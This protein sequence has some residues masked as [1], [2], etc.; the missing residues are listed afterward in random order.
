MIDSSSVRG[1]YNRFIQY[2][3]T[4]IIREAREILN[5]YPNTFHEFI[6]TEGVWG[7]VDNDGLMYFGTISNYPE[8]V[9]LLEFIEEWDNMVGISQ[10][11]MRFTANG[12]IKTTW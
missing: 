6:M 4:E 7:F 11:S 5:F 2:I 8:V 12:E 3:V 9:K 10:I 1:Y